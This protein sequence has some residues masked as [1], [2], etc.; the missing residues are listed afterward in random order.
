[1]QKM[2]TPQPLPWPQAFAAFGRCLVD[3]ARSLRQ[4]RL[5]QPSTN[6]GRVIAFADGTQATVYR[7]TVHDNGPVTEP[8]SL[9]VAFRLRWVG[10][11]RVAHRLFWLESVCNTVLFAGF[12]GFVTKLWMT[13]DANHVYRGIYEWDGYDSAVDYVRALWWPLMIVSRRDS[14]RFH[15]VGDSTRESLLDGTPGEPDGSWWRPV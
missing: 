3:V 5:H 11:N 2:S 1:M 10:G 14:I 4:R 15:V 7:E 6:L 13:A 8:V 12:D 9:I